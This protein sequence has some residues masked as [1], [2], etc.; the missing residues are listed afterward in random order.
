[1]SIK[2]ISDNKYVQYILTLDDWSDNAI[3]WQKINGDVYGRNTTIQISS[4]QYDDLIFSPGTP[5]SIKLISYDSED[6][7]MVFGII[8]AEPL[9]YDTIASDLQVGQKVSFEYKENWTNIRIYKRNTN[10]AEINVSID[11]IQQEIKGTIENIQFS[12]RQ[13]DNLVFSPNTP[14]IV[15]LVE[16][17]NANKVSIFGIISTEPLVY[18]TI[19][20]DIQVGQEVSFEYKENW[21]NIRLYQNGTGNI[22]FDVAANGINQEIALLNQKI[23]NIE[24]ESID[25]IDRLPSLS[26]NP[27]QKIMREPG[28]GSIIH[29][30]GIIGD[31]LS[32]G[33][34]ECREIGTTQKIFLDRFEYSWGQRLFKLLGVEGYNFSYSGQQT[35]PWCLGWT[36]IQTTST[37]PAT[38]TTPEDR[39]W[40]GEL[41]GVT[42]Q[43]GAKYNPKQGY[44]IA[45]G[46]N[47]KSRQEYPLGTI[48]DINLNDYTQNGN[49]FYGWY[50]GIIQRVRSINSRCFVF[51]VT[52]PDNLGD[53]YDQAI[54]DI[55]GL[56]DRC[57]CIDLAN[58]VNYN[59]DFKQ[60]Y[61]LGGHMN[62]AGYEYTAYVMNTYIDWIIRNNFNDFVDA[63][64]VGTQYEIVPD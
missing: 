62:A 11:S 36:Q 26:E 61:Y 52:R 41:V 18:E 33:S 12:S 49:S 19:A 23:D 46:V 10:T 17:E 54:R 16:L 5:V 64:V 29:S 14:I 55:V 37:P 21:T 13:Y 48:T 58:G 59:A 15:K 32:S 63:A 2:F 6:P 22:I 57:Y 8:S 44:I 30:W 9:V 28:Y 60:R 34:T 35:K 25:S 1:M 40:D 56:F 42:G 24:L 31:S 20:S 38:T 4:R 45:M 53:T 7:L 3:Y 51:C 39:I 47:D 43:H 50:A 27:L